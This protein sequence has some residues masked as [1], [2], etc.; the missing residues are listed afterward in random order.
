[1]LLNWRAGA[2]RWTHA[3][4]DAPLA[5]TIAPFKYKLFFIWLRRAQKCDEPSEKVFGASTI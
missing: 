5:E 4:D 2:A 3:K 1:M